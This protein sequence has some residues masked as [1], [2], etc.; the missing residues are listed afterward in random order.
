MQ[1]VDLQVRLKG[2]DPSKDRRFAGTVRLPNETRAKFTVCV[3]GDHADCEAAKAAGI[4]FRT[5]EDLKNMNRNKKLVKKLANS[6]HAFLASE[7][8]IKRIPRIL[9]PG[10]SKAGKFPTVLG[11]NESLED[12]IKELHQTIK[13]QLKKEINLGTAVGH[14]NLTEDQLFHNISMALNFLVSLLKKN[15]QNIGS[16]TIKSSMGKNPQRI[17]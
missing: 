12:K 11:S 1:T 10:L 9:G 17:Y 7:S 8:M 15:W 16:V 3:L 2:Y 14:V 13:F 4:P 6:Y 5:V